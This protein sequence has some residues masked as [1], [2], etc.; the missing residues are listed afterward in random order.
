MLKCPLRPM[1]AWLSAVTNMP[2]RI[3][4]GF[5]FIG[6]SATGTS[7]PDGVSAYTCSGMANSL[8]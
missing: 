4:D 2:S 8:R 1:G 7:K 6:V 5:F 3:S